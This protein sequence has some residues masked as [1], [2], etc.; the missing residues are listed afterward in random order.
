MLSH[1]H[2]KYMNSHTVNQTMITTLHAPLLSSQDQF[3]SLPY[4][5]YLQAHSIICTLNRIYSGSFFFSIYCVNNHKQPKWKSAWKA[6]WTLVCKMG[7]LMTQFTLQNVM[8]PTCKCTVTLLYNHYHISQ[9]D[10]HP[11]T[12]NSQYLLHKPPR[13]FK[14]RMRRR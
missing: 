12:H 5:Q 1:T 9:N 4:P 14:R 10:A 7:M 11:Q 6:A 8:F 3:A 2:T 13:L